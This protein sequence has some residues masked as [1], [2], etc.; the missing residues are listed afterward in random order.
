MCDVS[1]GDECFKVML[2]LCD[3]VVIA[4]RCV[5]LLLFLMCSW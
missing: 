4:L 1:D 2:I 3:S 5:F